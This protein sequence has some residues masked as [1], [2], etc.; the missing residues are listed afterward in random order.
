MAATRVPTSAS[1]AP[2][3]TASTIP[4]VSMPGTYGAG[5]GTVAYRPWMPSMSLKLSVTASARTST[6]PGPGDGSSTSSS[7]RT[8]RGAP[9]STARQARTRL[10]GVERERQVGEPAH[11]A[12]VRAL[13]GLSQ[14]VGREALEQLLERDARLE[15]RQCRPDAEVDAEPEPHVPLDVAVDVEVL[16]VVEFAFVV[17]R[18]AG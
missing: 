5:T 1:S 17:V 3:P 8:S 9:C 11:V 12:G 18:R 10:R 2:S 16:G 6:S 15:P 4:S 13:H 14:L 7:R